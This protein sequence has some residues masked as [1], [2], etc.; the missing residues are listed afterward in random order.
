MLMVCTAPHAYIFIGKLEMLMHSK[1]QGGQECISLAG[2]RGCEGEAAIDGGLGSGPSGKQ[3]C[4][5]N[6]P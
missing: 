3:E 2:T 6:P 1:Y 5:G 4:E